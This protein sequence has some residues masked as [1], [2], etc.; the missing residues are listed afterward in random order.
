MMGPKFTIPPPG[1]VTA[2]EACVY[3]RGEH[4]EWCELARIGAEQARCGDYIRDHG[5]PTGRDPGAA[6]GAQDWLKE[7]ILAR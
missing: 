2:C 4:A 1:R 6:L 5:M 7:E 3:G